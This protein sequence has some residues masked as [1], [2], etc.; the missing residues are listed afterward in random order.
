[1]RDIHER[2]NFHENFLKKSP[3]T[4]YLENCKIFCSSP[5]QR[6]DSQPPEST[7][8]YS[9]NRIIISSKFWNFLT[10]KFLLKFSEKI[11]KN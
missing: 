11:I 5:I 4:S 2:F 6:Q 7:L 1:M 10:F 8:E 3:K 9:N